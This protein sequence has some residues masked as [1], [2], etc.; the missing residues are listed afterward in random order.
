MGIRR[1]VV[2]RTPKALRE[3]MRGIAAAEPPP[4][5]LRAADLAP[6]THSC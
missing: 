3:W 6:G 1:Q 4:R 5:R 2:R